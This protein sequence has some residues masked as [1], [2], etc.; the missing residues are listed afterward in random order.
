MDKHQPSG[1][2]DRFECA[3]QG[4]SAVAAGFGVRFRGPSAVERSDDD[5]RFIL[6]SDRIRARLARYLATAHPKPSR[7]A[8]IISARS[9]MDAGGL[10]AA[11][12]DSVVAGGV[13]ADERN[14]G[15]GCRWDGGSRSVGLCG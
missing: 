8:G 11:D 1:V 10:P 9:G 15:V 2:L 3:P 14:E 13:L 4:T 6:P 7:F 12:R 5:R